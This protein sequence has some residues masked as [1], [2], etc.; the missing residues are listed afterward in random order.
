MK[1]KFLAIIIP[2]MMMA[3]LTG[4]AGGSQYNDFCAKAADAAPLLLNSATGKEI[5]A[6][7][8][9]VRELSNY[10]SVLA[11]NTYTFQEKEMT[12]TWDLQPAEKW[13]SGAY[14]LDASRNKV[15]PVYGKEAFEASIKATV[16]YVE[17][18]KT[19]GKAELHWKFNIAATETVEMSLKQINEKFIENGNKLTGMDKDAE[20]K[21]IAIGTRGIIT[22]S[23]ESPDHV[24][25]GVFIS[26]G[27][28]STQLYAGSLGDLWKENQLKVGDCVFAVGPL[29]LYNGIIEMKPSLLDVIDAKAY[30]IAD[31]VTIDAASKTWDSSLLINQ[32]TLV[33]F[34][35]CVYSSGNVTANSS[36]AS[37]IFKHG[38]TSVTVYCNY[39]IGP[40]AMDAIKELVGG[41]TA[42][43]TKVTLKGILSFYNET[44]QIIPVF[45][46]NSFVAA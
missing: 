2:A 22:G 14:V 35:D 11:L 18:G 3:S 33:E 31:P 23:F 8:T 25:A 17:K 7:E 27:E 9:T 19:Q 28:Y 32:S 37:I 16:S 26:D 15:S 24:Y 12:I 36:H 42:D 45:G 39:H 40:T 46:A 13:V 34:K 43:T 21:D 29:S 5:F 38:E 4:C 10:N 30:N 6:S 20:G 44:P 1:K 41:Y